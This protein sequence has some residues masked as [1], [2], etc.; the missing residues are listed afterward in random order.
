MKYNVVD[1]DYI[2]I[3]EASFRIN[4]CVIRV[5]YSQFFLLSYI[6]RNNK[7]LLKNWFLC[8]LFLRNG[9][10][11][12]HSIINGSEAWKNSNQQS[13]AFLKYYVHL[14]AKSS[15]IFHSKQWL[16]HIFLDTIKSIS[17]I[18]IRSY[19]FY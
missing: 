13:V 5:S 6:F 15:Y 14:K 19:N 11:E 17:N 3:K 8:V 7:K 18:I 4:H 10:Q 16:E 2:C 12:N 9:P 1:D